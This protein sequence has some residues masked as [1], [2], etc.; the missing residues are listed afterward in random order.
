VEA[1]AAGHDDLVLA[2]AEAVEESLE[3]AG[4]ADAAGED[5]DTAE[6]GCG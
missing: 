6:R 1:Y 2:G 3:E 4:P 5:G